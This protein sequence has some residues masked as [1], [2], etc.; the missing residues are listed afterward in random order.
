M[1][2]LNCLVVVQSD[3]MKV[4]KCFNSVPFIY[5]TCLSSVGTSRKLQSDFPIR[6]LHLKIVFSITIDI[7]AGHCISLLQLRTYS[8][9]IDGG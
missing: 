4:K 7:I 9:I 5:E 8:D 3:D 2:N 6:D 1:K